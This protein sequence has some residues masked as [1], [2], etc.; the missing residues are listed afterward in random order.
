MN[1]IEA[2]KIFFIATVEWIDIKN[3]S[4]RVRLVLVGSFQG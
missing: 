4:L 3:I 2:L 1:Y